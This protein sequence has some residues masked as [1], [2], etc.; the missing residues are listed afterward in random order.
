MYKHLFS[1]RL[2]GT[3]K[4]ACDYHIL[5]A[6]EKNNDFSLP[7]TPTSTCFIYISSIPAGMHTGN[8]GISD[9]Y[10]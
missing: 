5:D 1:P 3:G 9:P 4:V 8:S 2:W 6:Q 10:N 7:A